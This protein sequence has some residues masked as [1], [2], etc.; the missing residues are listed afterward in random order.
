MKQKDV[1]KITK[2]S[3][4][5]KHLINN[6]KKDIS[7]GFVLSTGF[8]YSLLGGKGVGFPNI[9]ILHDVKSRE[10]ALKKAK[11]IVREKYEKTNIRHEFNLLE[12]GKAID[13]IVSPDC[14]GP[15]NYPMCH[16][17][18]KK[19]NKRDARYSETFNYSVLIYSCS[20]DL[21]GGKFLKML[22]ARVPVEIIDFWEKKEIF[23][24]HG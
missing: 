18:Y 4:I 7:K 1:M 21:I 15:S 13:R 19:G 11:K 16:L 22:S 24:S 12:D 20:K 9:I 10:E 17:C 23:S 6:S 5:G 2:K 8:D 3:K 14:N